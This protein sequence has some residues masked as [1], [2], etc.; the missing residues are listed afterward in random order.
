MDRGSVPKFEDFV[1]V[2][3]FVTGENFAVPDRGASRYVHLAQ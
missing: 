2:A 1:E 3:D